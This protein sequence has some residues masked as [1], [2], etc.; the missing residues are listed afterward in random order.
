MTDLST[1]VVAR[2][3]APGSVQDAK[4]EISIARDMFEHQV[5]WMPTTSKHAHL[6]SA[7]T[8]EV[9]QAAT[10]ARFLSAC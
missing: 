4:Q 2:F 3:P 5:V 7:A 10:G 1:K 6:S 9:L 8:P